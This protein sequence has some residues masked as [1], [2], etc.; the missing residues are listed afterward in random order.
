MTRI[1]D[2][3]LVGMAPAVVMQIALALRPRPDITHEELD[4]LFLKVAHGFGW[5]AAHF[6]PAKTS[7]GW[8]TAVAGDGKGFLDWVLVKDR[9]LVIELKTQDDQLRPEQKEWVK[10]WEDAGVEVHAFWPKDW[11]GLVQSLA[12]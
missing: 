11:D 7:K 9:V 6:R 5:K 1:N 12:P 3:Q 10:A 2:D 8:R 4:Q